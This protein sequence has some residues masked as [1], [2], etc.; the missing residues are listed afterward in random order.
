MAEASTIETHLVSGGGL[1]ADQLEQIRGEAAAKSIGV[2]EAILSLEFMQPAGL[3]EAYSQACSLPYVPLFP[4]P[5]SPQAHRM[6]PQSCVTAWNV[7]PVA[8]DAEHNLLTLAIHDLK[9]IEHL[10]KLS[11]LFM[12]SHDLAFTVAPEYEIKKAVAEHL[13]GKGAA[14]AGGEQKPRTIVRS[15]IGS[16]NGGKKK[17]SAIGG[18]SSSSGRGRIG[19]PAAEEAGAFSY[20]EMSKAFSSA[21]SVLAEVHLHEQA[22]R[23][24]DVRSCVRYCQLLSARMNLE[25]ASVDAVISAAWLSALS[26]RPELIKRITTPYRLDEII[27]PKHEDGDEKAPLMESSILSLVLCYHDLKRDDPDSVKDV[28][29]T[30][31][32]LRETWPGVATQ[33]ELLETFL[34]VLM[35]EQFLA[36]L[37]AGTGKVLLVDGNAEGQDELVPALSSRGFDVTLVPDAA[38][39][40]SRL[41]EGAPDLILLDMNLT[42]AEDGLSFCE[43]VKTTA[44]TENVPVL[45]LVPEEEESRAAKCLV[46]G[47][48]D[49][50]TRPVSSDLLMIKLQRL[51]AKS[52]DSGA[53]KDSSQ[54]G[55]SGSLADMGFTDMVQILCAGNRTIQLSLTGPSGTGSVFIREG[56][57]IHAQTDSVEGDGAFY[58]MMHWKEGEFSTQQPEDF[59]EQTIFA[60]L[61]SLLMEGARQIDEGV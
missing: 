18:R 5:S 49:Y 59:P 27:F 22:Q 51:F 46:A 53:T 8:F 56:D 7:Y 9:Q 1:S 2:D 15:A 24:T 6:L 13:S 12:Q 60:G 19:K 47:A 61:M 52:G 32:H 35:D 40:D 31:R 17:L 41:K 11:R 58:A 4:D 16:S 45:M 42:P 14:V 21:A 54:D 3:A 33:Q 28:T 38:S 44:A 26:D 43:R 57:V 55:V 29:L 25:P 20:S 37:D 36:T 34:Q 39:A 48:D 50:L 23:L 30:R 10:E